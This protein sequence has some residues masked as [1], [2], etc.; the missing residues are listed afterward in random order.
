M[1]EL[2]GAPMSTVATVFAVAFG[3]AVAFLV[4][5]RLRLPILVRMAIRNVLRR[6]GQSLLII[7]GLMLATAII[8]NAFTV[9]DPVTYSLKNTAADGSGAIEAAFF[10]NGVETVNVK[11]LIS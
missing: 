11:E 1:D 10:Q 9:G 2:C 5:I 4:Y 6:P 3:I 8:S 7:A